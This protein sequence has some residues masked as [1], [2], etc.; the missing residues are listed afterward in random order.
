M[1]LGGNLLA[2]LTNSIW[3]VLVGLAVVPLYLKYLGIEAFGL[4]G[5]FTTLQALFQL[6][7]LGFAATANREVARR[8]ASGNLRESGNLLH[9][10]AVIYWGIAGIIALIVL[11]L[12]P[13]LAQHWLQSRQLPQETVAR[14]VVLMGLT[15]AC[16]WPIGLYQ[17]ALMG[18]QRLAVSSGVN[19]AMVTLGNFGA[20]AVLALV[21]PTIQAFFLWQAGVGLL[22]A[23][24]VRWAAWRAV[25]RSEGVRFDVD[26]LRRIWRFSAGMSGIAL[27]SLMFTQL[28][29]VLLSKVLGL[30]DFGRYML[31]TVVAGALSVLITP[32]FNAMYPRFCA[33]VASGNTEK[34]AD[35]YRL[36][37][38]LLAT[39]LFPVATALAMFSEELLRV[40]TGNSEIAS[41]VAPVV[42]LLAIG[43]A[44][45]GVMH[46]PYALQLAFGNTRLP[47]TINCALTIVMFPLTVFLALSYGAMG[48][49]V[50]WLI[51][52]V[53]Y[54]MLGTW[55]TH[56]H[57]LR[58]LAP[59]WLFQD[60]GFSFGLSVLVVAVG[61]W[62][63]RH[64]ELSLY[65]RLAC[66]GGLAAL[67]CVLSWLLSPQLRSLARAYIGKRTYTLKP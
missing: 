61:G 8:S 43:S 15:L 45:N 14:A 3:T 52:E 17:G 34:L 53:L 31:A 10:L 36:G 27:S 41:S 51:V 21:S 62:A 6:L 7:D 23:A 64:L 56:R 42:T 9:T 35:L 22:H 44:L 37:T 50:A 30:E 46:F 2:G 60:V 5:F 13:F 1:K 49:A 19:I 20:V 29:K 48:G 58:S 66:G 26:E 47:L 28:D 4:I 40:W 59:T 32:T 33:L 24:T 57:L 54:V 18:A 16:R 38:R 12:A 11:A 39:V 65:A 63:L 25:G 67:A 55:L